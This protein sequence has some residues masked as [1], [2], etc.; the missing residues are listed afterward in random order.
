MKKKLL[1][2]LC[3]IIILSGF[4]FVSSVSAANL[5]PT[6]DG[7]GY[8]CADSNFPYYCGGQCRGSQTQ[9]AGAGW[10]PSP[11]CASGITCTN[12]ATAD[13]CGYG[14]TCNSGYTLC[15]ATWPNNTCVATV[16][17]VSPCSSYDS[18][19]GYCSA[20]IGGYNYCSSNHSCTANACTAAQTWNSSTCSCT[21]MPAL[22]LGYDS[23][24]GTSIIQSATYPILYITPSSNVGIGTT[25]PNKLLEVGGM[26]KFYNYAYGLTPLSTDIPALTTVEY[27]NGLVGGVNWAQGGNTVASLKNFGT[28]N[29]FDLPF[30]TSS[31]ERMRILAGG[32]IGIGITNP[33]ETLDV[34]GN[35]KIEGTNRLNVAGYLSIQS[36]L[37]AGAAWRRGFIGS[38][39]YW[40]EANGNWQSNA[41]GAGDLAGISFNNAGTVSIIA[42]NGYTQPRTFTTAEV[43]AMANMTFL[44]NGNVGIGTTNPGSK[45]DV[46]GGIPVNGAFNGYS[47]VTANS[48]NPLGYSPDILAERPNTIGTGLTY[49]GGIGLGA[50][51]GIYSINDNPDGSS[52]YGDIRFYT[53]VWN[54][55]TSQYDNYDRMIITKTGNVG[56]GTTNPGTRL[57]VYTAVPVQFTAYNS[58]YWST[59]NPNYNLRLQSIWNSGINF[60][61]IQKVNG[62]DN[63]V[64]SFYGGNVGIGTTTPSKLLEVNG[65]AKFNNF[66]YGTTP[67]TSDNYALATVEYVNG[68]TLSSGNT[69]TTTAAGD[70]NMGGH[71]ILNVAKLTVNTIDPLYSIGEI[72][73]S[74]YAPSI[75]GG[76]KEEYVGK[77]TITSHNPNNKK[78]YEKIINFATEP[79]GS[80]LWV[81]RRVVDFS[82]DNVEVLITP[83]GHFAN[84]YYLIKKNQLILRSDRPVTLAYRLIGRRF[85]WSKWPT[86]ALDQ[87]EKGMLVE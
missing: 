48:I 18:C 15:S 26:A 63:N 23:V 19:N 22:K 51:V 67:I 34:N 64:L 84:A 31:T 7:H 28:L 79:T 47:G 9:C 65:M 25:T 27:V 8:G 32:N 38:N 42:R 85:D 81:W 78:E 24:S 14:Y 57:D 80:D 60:N 55:G 75:S 46:T 73:Y 10:T 13:S 29:N 36:P 17:A 56:V 21:N 76:V 49:R 54:G 45:L 37:T 44:T 61:F 16:A 33:A 87:T 53:T 41:A 77:V 4:L 1:F 50:G 58:Q 39:L 52:Y 82:S 11:V 74:T 70:L 68:K 5:C 43:D 86:K 66:A 83:Y 71:N 20:C 62:T 3:P 2:L 69:S 35:I 12:F 72:N 30:I 40:N 6:D 59:N